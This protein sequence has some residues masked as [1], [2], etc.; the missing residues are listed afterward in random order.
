M[1]IADAAR[2]AVAGLFLLAPLG[3]AEAAPPPN[4]L[5]FTNSSEADTIDPHAHFDVVRVASK[6][7]FYDN[8]YRYLDNP[9]VLTPWIAESYTVSEDRRTYR[10]AIRHGIKFH[11]GTPLTAADVVYS[12]DRMMSM[13]RGPASLFKE[14]LKPGQ[15]RAVD[16]YTVE[17]TLPEPSA[18][19]L[20]LLPELFI[21]NAKLV[22]A[23]EKDGDWGAAWLSRN[24]AGSGSFI[25]EDYDPAI[26]WTARWNPDHFLGWGPKHL[27]HLQYK[28]TREA[29]SQVLGMMRGDFHFLATTLTNDQ[30]QRLRKSPKVKILES[31]Q[32]RLFQFHINNQRP[33][34]DNVHVRRALAHAFDYDAFNLGILGGTVERAVAPLP[35]A[36]WGYPE[37]IEGY[38]FDLAKAKEEL[39]KW[40]GTFTQP[41]SIHAMVGITQTEQAASVLQSGLRKIGVDSRILLDT[42]PTLANKAG[43][44]ET[45][46]DV[47]TVWAGMNYPDPHNWLEGYTSVRWGTSKGGSWYKNPEVDAMAA[48]ALKSDDKAERQALYEKI[49]RQ[50][51][52]DAAALWIYSQR[53][54]GAVGRD[55]QGFRYSPIGG[56]Q[57]FRW[58][59]MGPEE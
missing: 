9:P 11:D 36:M 7:N 12:V 10:F 2:I 6:N 55:V 32:L 15:A 49:T 34:F 1:R 53:W 57:D 29:N 44:V 3:V 5:V 28:T 19:F 20:P 33:P 30:I 25:L 26:G 16:D 42:Y 23:N 39:A 35:K 22:K 21:V 46:P 8:F 37:G 41:I 14:M 52:D 47:W 18:S 27:E 59:W 40:G 56:A 48:R 58:V 50:V 24:E 31:D 54:Y 38:A 17:F 45:T 13:N 4:T 51:V 43:K